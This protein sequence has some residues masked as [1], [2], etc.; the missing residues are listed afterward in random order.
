VRARQF[1]WDAK[2]GFPF[3]L[4]ISATSEKP[5]SERC[6]TST[7][8]P[9]R[10]MCAT[11]SRPKGVRPPE[12]PFGSPKQFGAFQVREIRRMKEADGGQDEGMN[13]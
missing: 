13:G 9:I 11:A 6:E 1:E 3:C 5:R 12:L 4:Q 10:F 2:K 8:I 7:I